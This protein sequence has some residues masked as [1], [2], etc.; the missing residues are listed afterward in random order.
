MSPQYH[1][2]L[3]F[4]LLSHLAVAQEQLG[5]PVYTNE[6]KGHVYELKK[7]SLGIM[8]F[9]T[10]D[11]LFSY[12]G[13]QTTHFLDTFNTFPIH[14]K[15]LLAMEIDEERN[16]IW[17][18]N[19]KGLG[20]FSKFERR[21]YAP[22]YFPK[23]KIRDLYKSSRGD[24]FVGIEKEGLWQYLPEKDSFVQVLFLNKSLFPKSTLS[25]NAILDIVE[26]PGMP[27][28]FWIATLNG[29]IRWDKKAN[30]VKLLF[31]QAFD[32][33]PELFPE[34]MYSS[35]W[36]RVGP[37]GNVYTAGWQGL[38]RFEPQTGR[39]E[40]LSDST[41]IPPHKRALNWSARSIVF[42]PN[43]KGWVAY[44]EY[45]TALYDPGTNRFTDFFLDKKYG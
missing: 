21:L 15:S 30:E 34:S 6:I 19:D 38:F 32:T 45:G 20:Y 11:G 35:S 10:P 28:L 23:R 44:R 17:V 7:D 29:L 31:P 5:W 24:I 41:L 25:T 2:T 16:R 13:N 33:Q 39:F 26:D 42:S 9:A 1:I 3:F 14:F 12:D 18:G 40:L 37:H 22:A 43:G 27:E 36:I 8:W 4:L